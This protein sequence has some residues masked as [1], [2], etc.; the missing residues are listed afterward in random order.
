MSQLRLILFLGS[1]I[2][3]VK[4]GYTY[5]QN[6]VLV[7]DAVPSVP[8]GVIPTIG[9]SSVAIVNDDK[10][11]REFLVTGGRSSTAL[12][13]KGFLYRNDCKYHRF[14]FTI[15]INIPSDYT[16]TYDLSVYNLFRTIPQYEASRIVPFY[17]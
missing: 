12:S 10:S 6:T 8:G 3:L 7:N 11:Y 14:T 13:S 4:L 15:F 5:A 17:S 1:I 9:S 2:L 16:R